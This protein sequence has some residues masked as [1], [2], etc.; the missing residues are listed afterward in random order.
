MSYSRRVPESNVT[1]LCQITLS[2][3][4]SSYGEKRVT[5]EINVLR[6][7]SAFTGR[8]TAHWVDTV[9]QSWV[10]LPRR[11]SKRGSTTTGLEFQ[12]GLSVCGGKLAHH[13]A[14][15]CA[16]DCGA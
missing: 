4:T 3:L 11:R 10:I 12:S 14:E 7:L 2:L 9:G 1:S 5:R 6:T 15:P 16:A 13:G 8:T